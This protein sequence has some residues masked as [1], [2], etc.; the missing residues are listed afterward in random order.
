MR[1]P[2]ASGPKTSIS[3]NAS[4]TI[5]H[6]QLTTPDKLF[7]THDD[8]DMSSHSEKRKFEIIG[9]LQQMGFI[10]K[11]LTKYDT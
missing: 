5:S 1:E 4:R 11:S 8:F 3:R 2:Y 7:L 10:V 9:H 6:A